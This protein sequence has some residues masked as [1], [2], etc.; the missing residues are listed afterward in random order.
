M[1]T[2][3]L[4]IILGQ[5]PKGIPGGPTPNDKATKAEANYT[6]MTDTESCG[7]CEHF[8]AGRCDLVVGSID[9]DYVCDYWEARQ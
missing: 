7:I 5:E 6:K 1:T 4:S 2:I 3:N 8:D 9:A